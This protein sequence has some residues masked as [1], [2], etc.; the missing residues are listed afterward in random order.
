MISDKKAS[1]VTA[2]AVLPVTSTSTC[3]TDGSIVIDCSVTTLLPVDAAKL[4]IVFQSAPDDAAVGVAPASCA[5][6]MLTVAGTVGPVAPLA[7][8]TVSI[9]PCAVRRSAVP[10][11][12]LPAALLVAAAISVR[13]VLVS[14][15]VV[16]AHITD[17]CHPARAA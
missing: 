17:W 6:K 14:V 16:M 3:I 10:R 5:I 9:P 8:L 1:H 15:V 13:G 12:V 2:C 7:I 4:Q 11:V